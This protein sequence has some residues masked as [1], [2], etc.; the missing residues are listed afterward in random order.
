MCSALYHRSTVTICLPT[1][2]L[3]YNQ[4]Q[5]NATTAPPS[6]HH[7]YIIAAV[8]I[9]ISPATSQSKG[10]RPSQ[11]RRHTHVFRRLQRLHLSFSLSLSAATGFPASKGY[12]RPGVVFVL[13]GSLVDI[14]RQ[15]S[16]K[17]DVCNIL[18]VNRFLEDGSGDFMRSSVPAGSVKG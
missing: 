4:Q 2:T 14:F 18:V 17:S 10:F 7:R 9:S 1:L 5:D 16:I 12:F 8:F 6:K 3:I 13:C 11:S 15:V